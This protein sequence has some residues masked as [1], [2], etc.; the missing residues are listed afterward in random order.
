[1]AN[2]ETIRDRRANGRIP[3]GF[4]IELRDLSCVFRGT[5]TDF[6]PG[7][8]R[9]RVGG[10]AP[11]VNTDVEIVLR[12][13]GEPP[14]KLKGRVMHGRGNEAGV[15]FAVGTPEYFEA[16]LNLYESIVM[17]D[18]KL[19]IQLKKRPTSLPYSQRLWPVPLRGGQLSGPEH[20]VYSRLA[21]S[22]TVLSE[23][24]RAIGA[25]WPHV[26]HVPFVLL[27]RGFASLSQPQEL[28]DDPRRP[29]VPAAP[30]GPPRRPSGSGWPKS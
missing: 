7:G 16:A 14:V 13:D 18:P 11:L 20:W 26:A 19:A 21:M 10:P 22:G 24:R 5:A 30:S 6:S 2:E 4:Q 8:M 29:S 28:I 23:L 1:M 15:A 12:P 9:V 27:E 25:E 3:V 17:R